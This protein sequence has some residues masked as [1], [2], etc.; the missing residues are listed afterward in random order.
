MMKAHY[1]VL[2]LLLATPA[3]AQTADPFVDGK[4]G[5][6]VHSASGFVCPA[7]IG[8]FERDTASESDVETGADACDYA[9]LDGIY[10]TIK[11]IPLSGPYSPR[12]S[13]AQDFIEQEGTGGKRVGESVL[14]L[15]PKT[16]A[17]PVYARTYRTA[18]AEAL[19]YRILFAGAQIGN[20]A[21]EVTVEYADPR[22]T[23]AEKAFL[24]AVYDSARKEI[25]SNR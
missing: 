8:A 10:G 25:S 4:N 23:P 1:F 16:S 2:A 22:D 3:F 11:L 19:E 12:D 17:L 7:K 14:M 21:V 24:S 18:R 6:K 5:A 20:W 13:M 9:A 15:G